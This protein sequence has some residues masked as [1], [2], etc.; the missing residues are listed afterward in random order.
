LFYFFYPDACRSTSVTL[1][2]RSK[3]TITRTHTHTHM[4]TVHYMTDATNHSDACS[5]TRAIHANAIEFARGVRELHTAQ[6]TDHVTIT[7]HIPTNNGRK[8]RQQLEDIDA[9]E[10]DG[11]AYAAYQARKRA[12]R[13][14]VAS[15]DVSQ[16]SSQPEEQQTAI[17]QAAAAPAYDESGFS[18]QTCYCTKCNT[19]KPPKEFY[20]S[21]LRRNVF[22]CKLCSRT[23]R[24]AS[25]AKAAA[26]STSRKKR[27]AARAPV[28][29]S[30]DAPLDSLRQQQQQYEKATRS[31]HKRLRHAYRD[32]D[33]FEIGFNAKVVR[34]LL[35][36]WGHTSAL[37]E[38]M[39]PDE[40]S[41]QM[42]EE[43]KRQGKQL[44]PASQLHLIVWLNKHE[45]KEQLEPWQVVPV[46]KAQLQRLR[47]VPREVW[48]QL[49]SPALIGRIDTR[50]AELK[51]MILYTLPAAL[52]YK[53]T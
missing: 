14:I 35:S 30:M 40:I 9:S 49:L 5:A 13:T 29:A 32:V 24:A 39:E 46:T 3:S 12:R 27:V 6:H 33:G 26:A 51:R 15:V 1:Y 47:S 18:K 43:G 28:A 23:Q 20:A 34:Q 36:F 10:S 44:L 31:V 21:C 37:E 7:P 52:P 50:L 8:R 45:M 11:S 25:M 48:P 22:Y 19:L 41:Q 16:A 4:S 53:Y 2:N 17:A 42:A 38:K